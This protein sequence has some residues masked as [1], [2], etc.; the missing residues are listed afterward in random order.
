MI[1]PFALELEGLHAL[2]KLSEHTDVV[3]NVSFS[4]DELLFA[5]CSGDCSILLWEF[6]SLSILR[7]FDGHLNG[8]FKV[9]FSPCQKLIASASDDCTLRLWDISTGAQ[10]PIKFEEHFDNVAVW[11]LIPKEID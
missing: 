6:S 9:A 2:S 8:V 1:K 5:S 4:L 3:W 7:K 11:F 10:S